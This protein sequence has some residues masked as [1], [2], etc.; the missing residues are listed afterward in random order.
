MRS[1]L[2]ASIAVAVCLT[3]LAAIPALQAKPRQAGKRGRP[4]TPS[5]ESLPGV[6]EK[7]RGLERVAGLLPLYHDPRRGRLWLELP[8]PGADGTVG[9]YLYVEGLVSG[10]GSNPLFL[11]RG[12]LGDTRLIRLRRVGGRLLVE[13]PNLAFR[14]LTD[15]PAEAR[16]VEESFATSVLWGGELAALDPDGRAL[17][18]FTTFVVRDAHDVAARLGEAQQGEFS[19]DAARSAIDLTRC[20]SF[21]DNLE[22]EA[23]LTFSGGRPGRHLRGVTPT[24]Q[25][26]TVVQHHS[27]LRLPD[28]DYRP[29]EFD[30]RAGSFAVEFM[31]YAAPLDRPLERRWIVRHRLQKTDPAAARSTVREPI[32]YYVDRG[33]PEPVRSALVEGAAWWAA[34]FEAA[35]FVDAFRVELLPEGAHPLDARYNV[36][37]WV[38]R[39]TRGWS[40]GGGVVDPRTGEMIKGHVSLGSLRVRHDRLLFEG[41]VG[42]GRTGR[43]GPNDPLQ[44]ALARIRQLAAHEVG[45]TLGFTH[46]FAASS[47]AGRASVMDYPA[48]LVGV[49]DDGSFDLSDAYGVGVGEWDRHT[50]RY[51][52]GEFAPGTDERAALAGI[53][54]DGVRRGLAFLSDADARPAGAAHPLAN[55]WDN[56]DDPVAGLHHAMRVRRLALSRFGRD[57]VASGTPLALLQEVLVPVY[58]HHRYQVDAAL[59]VLGGMDYA[60]AVAGD[61]RPPARPLAAARQQDALAAVLAVLDPAALELPDHVVEL[62]LPRPFGYR[63]NDEMFAGG[64]A[65][66]FDAGA[67]AASL[68]AAVL[69]GLL[70]RERVTRLVEFHRRDVAQPGLERVLATTLDRLFGAPPPPERGRRE[71]RRIVQGVAVE[72][73]LRLA[74]DRAAPSAVRW[75]V[76][77]AL[78]ALADRLAEV[79]DDDDD[80]AHAAFLRGEVERFLGRVEP[81]GER[82]PEAPAMPPGQ[83]IGAGTPWG[84]AGCSQDGP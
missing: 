53:V 56:G 30:P 66:A 80:R 45:H 81:A 7:I 12:Q 50:V 71:L 31:D 33:A 40:Y 6:A 16:A 22:L 18:D 51:A 11:D 27:I 62:M 59:K 82:A 38:H 25:A 8:P 37:Q 77:R 46:N 4:E 61:G 1:V 83:P 19:L 36:I 24:P 39:S 73:L 15:E 35:G 57:N 64:A 34:A 69:D 10:I 20:L 84:A 52:Y 21:P 76:E 75:R 58:F 68:A 63:P 65:P 29:R 2:R 78:G 43:G 74:S 48:P 72:R 9:R 44:V 54:Q 47:Y 3:L 49:R 13:Q 60:Y 70:N 41:L 23:V 32:V 5:G 42:A 55:L 14:A 67:A 28:D 26:V 79:G 17:V